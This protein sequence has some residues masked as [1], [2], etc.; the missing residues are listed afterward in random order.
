MKFFTFL[1]LTLSLSAAHAASVDL[2]LDKEG[3]VSSSKKAGDLHEISF[4]NESIIDIDEANSTVGIT[5]LENT[6]EIKV[7]KSKLQDTLKALTEN[8]EK[9]KKE[10]SEVKINT[11]KVEYNVKEKVLTNQ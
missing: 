8:F 9:A 1:F 7:E 11:L 3:N 6:V 5:D 2:F 4:D 10:G